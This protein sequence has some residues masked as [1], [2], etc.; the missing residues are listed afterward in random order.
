M[1]GRDIKSENWIHLRSLI[2]VKMFV[3]LLLEGNW[4]KLSTRQTKNKFTGFS[5]YHCRLLASIRLQPNMPA[6][7]WS[8]SFR[9][10]ILG[11]NVPDASKTLTMSP[12]SFRLFSFNFF[13]YLNMI[14]T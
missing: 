14:F 9:S 10:D 8:Y 1:K 4:F 7:H 12:K 2:V 3:F 11:E 5:L 6:V 13:I